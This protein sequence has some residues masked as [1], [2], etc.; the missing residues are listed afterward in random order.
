MSSRTYELREQAGSWNEEARPGVDSSSSGVRR[1]GRGRDLH[2]LQRDEEVN[3]VHRVFLVPA[4]D[5]PRI[6]LFAGVEDP[7][8]SAAICAR[9][10]RNLALQTRRHVC[11]VDA[12]LRQ[13]TLQE[14]FDIGGAGGLANALLGEDA[15]RPVP[16][17]QDNGTLSVLPAGSS[18]PEPY[19][20]FVG[21]RLREFLGRL[22][23]EFAFVLISAPPFSRCSESILLSQAADGVVLVVEAH[24]TRREQALEVKQSIE[25]AR[26][27]L[28]GVVLNNRTFPSPEPLDR[29]L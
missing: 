28:L 26:A 7:A 10:G 2:A 25:S 5:A 20:L 9:V 22:R 13:P 21:T 15:V 8:A 24:S 19:R 6:V 27:K 23:D 4:A 1:A 3:L 29:L 18:V 14:H 11:V 16:Q 12:N 17:Q